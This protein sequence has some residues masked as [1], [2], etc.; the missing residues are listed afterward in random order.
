MF[1]MAQKRSISCC[2]MF[3]MYQNSKIFFLTPS[4]SEKGA[5]IEFKGKAC[6]IY[7]DEKKYLI[8]H[9]HGKLCKL[10][11]LSE[12]EACYIRQMAHENYSLWLS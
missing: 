11:T 1:P 10:D 9:K 5:S 2:M 8:G 12:N 7:A 4:I 6:G 3:F